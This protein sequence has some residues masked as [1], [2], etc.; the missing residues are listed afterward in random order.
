[1]LSDPE[2]KTRFHRAVAGK[3][4]EFPDELERNNYLE[5]VCSRHQIPPDAL[6]DMVRRVGAARPAGEGTPRPNVQEMRHRRSREKEE[7]LL[8]AQRLILSWVFSE[9]GKPACIREYLAPE[10]F[11][12]AVC[13]RMAQLIWAA[14]REGQ[15]P[16]PA[17]LM[18]YFLDSEEERSQVAAVFNTE[19][20]PERTAEER[21]KILAESIRRIRKNSLDQAARR[22]TDRER[23]QEII[24][25]K[26][27][28]ETRVYF[29]EIVAKL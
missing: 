27:R 3:L 2:Q 17:S 11:T 18:N 7:G 13:G 16:E 21:K 12:D 25:Q 4:T 5:A 9:E 24:R 10:D 1:D 20:P 15:Q 29:S 14:W 26:A 6:R 8:E 19:L 28:V 22:E 23:L